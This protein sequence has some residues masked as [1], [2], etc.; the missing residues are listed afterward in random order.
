MLHEH[1]FGQHEQRGG[2]TRITVEDVKAMIPP[3]RGI[4]HL[5][6]EL[7]RKID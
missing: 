3:D 7:R 6:V 5:T 1:H 2:E 4:E